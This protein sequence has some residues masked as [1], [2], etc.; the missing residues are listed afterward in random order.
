MLSELRFRYLLSPWVCMW[1]WTAL[2]L[3]HSSCDSL[4]NP[5]SSIRFCSTEV[6]SWLVLL[7]NLNGMPYRRSLPSACTA[8]GVGVVPSIS[9]PE[10]SISNARIL[11]RA[12]VAV[13]MSY[14]YRSQVAHTAN[15]VHSL[16]ASLHPRVLV[17]S[18]P[19]YFSSL[20]ASM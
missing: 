20:V 14:R 18:Y 4:S 8:P 7:Q 11:G 13:A 3:V 15:H 17:D 2:R 5:A 6:D 9:V 16:I 1:V 12:I 10:M 19:Y